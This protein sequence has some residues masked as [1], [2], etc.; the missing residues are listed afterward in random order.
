M[1][2]SFLSPRPSDRAPARSP[3]LDAA[4]SAG[5][6]T[7]TR[8]GWE[9]IAS[10]G[11]PAAESAACAETVGFADLSP[12]PKLELSGGGEDFAPGVATALDGG[13]RCPVRR[14]RTLLLGAATSAAGAAEAAE[15]AGA[16]DVTAA[17]AAIVV[18]GPAA[19]ETFAR[20]CALD[21][22]ERSL[23]VGGFRPGSIARTPGYLLREGEDRFLMLF[24]SA[25][26][27]YA[28]GVVADAARRLGGRPVGA[29]SLPA[30]AVGAARA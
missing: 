29:G 18:A 24:G 25:Y 8:D 13:W 26:A 12:L 7:E 2:L 20:F 4:L 27:E 28:W 21:L 9:A 23:P 10:F 30:V 11:D 17:L 14:D 6:V 15:A 1:T 5:A 3:L 22:R 19:R 16:C